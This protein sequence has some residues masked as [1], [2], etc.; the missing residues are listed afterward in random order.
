MALSTI[1]SITCRLFNSDLFSLLF[2]LCRGV[3]SHLSYDSRCTFTYLG[4]LCEVIN[5]SI[6]RILLR[7]CSTECAVLKVDRFDYLVRLFRGC[8]LGM[9][10]L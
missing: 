7:V 10:C 1:S 4:D 9:G 6:N 8:Y 3:L 5:S 2:S